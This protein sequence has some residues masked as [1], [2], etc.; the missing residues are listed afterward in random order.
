MCRGM[1]KSCGIQVRRYTVR[2]VDLNEYLDSFPGDN[3]S[4]KFGS[5]ELEAR[6]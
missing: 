4:D 5:T 1:K 3:F 6:P 2:L